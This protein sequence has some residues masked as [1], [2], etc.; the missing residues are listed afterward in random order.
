[1][2]ILKWILSQIDKPLKM[3]MFR[4]NIDKWTCRHCEGSG[5]CRSVFENDYSCKTCIK[6]YDANE[7]SAEIT[8]RC[9]V[10]GGNGREKEYLEKQSSKLKFTDQTSLKK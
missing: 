7:V 2:D 3:L 5:V 8:V 6:E 1:M 9:S 10:C 4:F